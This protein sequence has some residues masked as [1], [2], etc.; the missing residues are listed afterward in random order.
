MYL[1][2]SQINLSLLT[3]NSIGFRT[4]KRN[5]EL[6]QDWK[7]KGYI[8]IELKGP[9]GKPN[10]VIHRNLTTSSNTSSFMLNGKS[11]SGK[12]ITERMV[13]LNVQVG[14]LW[15]ALFFR[16]RFPIADPL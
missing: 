2:L 14:N 16:Q 6:R 7:K 4:S 10:L 12:D 8:E 9:P 13:E 1:F 3:L 15:F 5:Q 11:A